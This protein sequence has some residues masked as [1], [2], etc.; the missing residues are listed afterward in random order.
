MI[1]NVKR[2]QILEEEIEV[3]KGQIQEHDTGH[4]ITA[5]NVLE[6]RVKELYNEELEYQRVRNKTYAE[7]ND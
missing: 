7:T 3:L 4:I 1:D 5:V 6:K 2:M